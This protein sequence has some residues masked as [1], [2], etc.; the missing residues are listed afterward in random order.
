MGDGV[1][2]AIEMMEVMRLWGNG[3][4]SDVDDGGESDGDDGV[5]G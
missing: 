3:N 1:M 4:G 5:M 2:G